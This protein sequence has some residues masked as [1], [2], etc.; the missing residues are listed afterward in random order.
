MG[1]PRNTVLAG[2]VATLLTLL[3][4][5]ASDVLAHPGINAVLRAVNIV[6]AVGFGA[7]TWYLRPRSRLGPLLVGIGFLF[8]LTTLQ[9][10]SA[11]LA[12]N[13]GRL[14]LPASWVALLYAFLAFPTGR[15]E[16]P[17]GGASSRSRRR[18][19]PRSGC[20][21]RSSPPPAGH[22]HPVA[23]PGRLPGEPVQRRQA[24]RPAG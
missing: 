24:P 5:A 11:S 2:T 21:M 9:A 18:P 14:L 17:A 12:Y 4:V 3:L 16:A 19:P 22:G 7:A 13:T 23:L 6:S 10:F 8:A 20:S 1:T 15:I